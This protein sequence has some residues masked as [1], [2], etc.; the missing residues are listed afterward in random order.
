LSIAQIGESLWRRASLPAVEP[1]FPARRKKPHANQAALEFSYAPKLPTPVPGGRDAALHVRQGCLT[2]H[3]G[4]DAPAILREFQPTPVL[5][6]H[7][8]AK[9]ALARYVM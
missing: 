9:G 7:D 3:G 6:I 2:L 1:G 4:A 5:T 8:M